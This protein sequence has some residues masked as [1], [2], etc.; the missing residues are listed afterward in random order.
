MAA[1]A[2]K[3]GGLSTALT[4][5]VLM[6]AQAMILPAAIVTLNTEHTANPANPAVRLIVLTVHAT[7]PT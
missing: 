3:T 6:S 5:A 7:H 4:D 1:K 2:A